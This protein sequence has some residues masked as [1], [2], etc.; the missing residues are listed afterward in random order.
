M[1]IIIEVSGGVVTGV[2]SDDA[3]AVVQ[4]VDYDNQDDD[5]GTVRDLEPKIKQM[6]ADG[7]LHTLEMDSFDIMTAV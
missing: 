2:H 6:I 7:T 1:T 4:V 5:S 3:D